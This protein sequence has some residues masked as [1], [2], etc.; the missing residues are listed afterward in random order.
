MSKLSPG[1]HWVQDPR[2]RV[3]NFAPYIQNVPDLKD[4]GFERLPPFMRSSRDEVRTS[5]WSRSHVHGC[6]L[7]N[8]K[9]G[10]CKTKTFRGIDFVFDRTPLSY[11]FPFIT[12]SR[13][14]S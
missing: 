5:P 1:V 11:L 4:F 2:S 7:G 9:F 8:A 3:Y 14:R 10:Y 6:F 12:R 13:S